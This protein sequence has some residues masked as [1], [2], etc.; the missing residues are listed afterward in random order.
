MEEVCRSL[1]A[2]EAELNRLSA[3]AAKEFQGALATAERLSSE[4][5][6]AWAEEGMSI[7]TCGFRSWEAAC[8]YFRATPQM[9]EILDFSHFMN[10]AK[11][12][13]QLCGNSFV[14]SSAY[15]R[16]SP[17]SLTLIPPHHI[18]QWIKLGMRLYKRNWRSTWLSCRFFEVSPDLLRYLDMEDMARFAL[19]IETLDKTSYNIASHCLESALAVFP[20]ID[21]EDRRGFLDS[22]LVLADLDCNNAKTYFEAGPAVLSRISRTQRS[23]FLALAARVSQLHSRNTLPFLIDCSRA[24]SQVERAL[25][26]QLL[27]LFEGLLGIS[28]TAAVEFLKSCPAVLGKIR[29]SDIGRWSVEG[30]RVLQESTEGGEAYFRLESNKGQQVLEHLSRGVE[31][32]RI[33]GILR[34]YCEALTGMSVQV[35]PTDSLVEK[36][37]GWASL[38]KPATEGSAIFL[39][40]FVD[41]YDTKADNFSFF[42]VLATHQAAHLEFGSFDFK[43]DQEARHFDNLR[44][45]LRRVVKGEHEPFTDFERF[46]DLFPDRR[47]AS[48]I[49]TAVEDGRV[50]YLVRNEYGGIRGSYERIQRDALAQRVSPSSL[51]LQRACLEILIRLSLEDMAQVSMPRKSEPLLGRMI[52]IAQQVKSVEARV[53]DSAEAT[54]R[55]Y[56]IISAIPNIVIPSEDCEAI[57]LEPEC[58]AATTDA[59]QPDSPALTGELGEPHEAELAY[60]SPPEVDFRGDFKPEVVQLL[61]KLKLRSSEQG[62]DDPMPALSPEALKELMEKWMEIDIACVW[63]GDITDSVGLF[64]NNLLNEAGTAPPLPL[65]PPSTKHEL[66]PYQVDEE[67]APLESDRPRSFAYDEWDFRAND[68][69][70]KWCLVREQSMDEGDVDFY[71]RT[72]ETHAGLASQIRRQF[73]LLTPESF[74]KVKRLHDGE[75]FELDAL[76]EAVVEKRAGT[77]PDEKIYWRR[78]K[79]QRDVSV[80]FLLDMSASTGEY[81]EEKKEE[82]PPDDDPWNYLAQLRARR[83]VGGGDKHKRI[84]DLEKESTVL[85]IKALEATGDAYGIYGFSGYGRDNVDYFVIKDLGEEFS[86]KV[87]KRIDR[88]EPVQA[89]RMGAAIRHAISKLE[90]QESRTKILFLISDGRPQDHGYSKDGVEKEYA[91]HDTKKALSEA[92]AKNIVPFC[93][94]VDKAGHD[95]LRTMCGDMRYEV[96][97]DV[98]SLPRRLPALYTRLTV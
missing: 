83:M 66:S 96:L 20:K 15:F 51:P 81:I 29:F 33:G 21:K 97:A 31:L 76:V 98:E 59:E 35:L 46:F 58:D 50:D 14:L 73:E 63:A 82:W 52:K 93:L 10:W 30:K 90:K 88:V 11:W 48:D 91:I 17:Q 89:T 56:S 45:T 34:L 25:H 75:G 68:Y 64:V 69:K 2:I 80:V 24:L 36:G 79:V 61:M 60:T 47:L 28:C 49:F 8:E 9:L 37:I 32:E 18:E 44:A 38:E 43:F 12:G 7:A 85:L 70:P 6:L 3:V 84:V 57:K 87:K 92:R 22:T 4:A 39:P 23:R 65:Q 13:R 95:Y 19:L 62:S 86:D 16:A 78:N 26:F 67:G 77:T 27:E 41:R 94:T 53:E 72:L 1:S 74:L 40:S 71:E 55:L 42:K 54:I 5:L